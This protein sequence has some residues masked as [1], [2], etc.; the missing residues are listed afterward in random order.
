LRDELQHIISLRQLQS[1]VDTLQDVDRQ[2]LKALAAGAPTRIFAPGDTIIRQGALGETFYFI[3][4]G[5]VEVFVS[6]DGGREEKIDQLDSGRY[7]GELALLG[8]RRRTATVRAAG[9]EP[10]RLLELDMA[11]FERLTRLSDRFAAGVHD[12]AADR[13]ARVTEGESTD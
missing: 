1:Q 7:F 4:E 8:D 2:E 11:A 9:E 13:R 5:Q 10:V 6:R 12:A 3:L